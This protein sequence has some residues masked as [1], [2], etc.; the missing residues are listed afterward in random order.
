MKATVVEIQSTLYNSTERR[1]SYRRIALQ[2][3]LPSGLGGPEIFRLPEE[4]VSATPLHVDDE[5]EVSFAVPYDG[6][7][8]GL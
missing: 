4:C 1:R 7:K 8:G 3:H 6:A 5:V 2:L